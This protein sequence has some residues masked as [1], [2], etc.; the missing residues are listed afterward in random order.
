MSTYVAGR[1]CAALSRALLIVGVW[2]A[3]SSAVY[4]QAKSADELVVQAQGI[5]SKG[6]P[7][8]AISILRKAI[9]MDPN[10]ADAYLVRARARDAAGKLEAAL[11]DA[12]KYIELKPNDAFGYLSRARVYMSLEKKNEALEDAS[13]EPDGYYRRSDIY[14]EMGKDAEGKADEAKA[15]ELDKKARS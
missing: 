15:D 10:N 7:D 1:M 6:R 2:A 5:L 13:K 9:E 14:Y 12:N 3:S 4:S 11:E 8:E